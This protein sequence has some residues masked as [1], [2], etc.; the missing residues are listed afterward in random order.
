MKNPSSTKPTVKSGQHP[1][2]PESKESIE[3]FPQRSKRPGAVGLANEAR[4]GLGT[5]G[6]DNDPGAAPA[7]E[8]DSSP[9]ADA[10]K[11]PPQPPEQRPSPQEQDP[12]SLAQELQRDTGVSGHMGGS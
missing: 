2:A 5:R 10:K 11:S 12:D 8:E 1:G 3:T 4:P 7:A 6:V 9:A